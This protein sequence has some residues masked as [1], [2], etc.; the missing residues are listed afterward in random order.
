MTILLGDNTDAG[1]TVSLSSNGDVN[2]VEMTALASG[3]IGSVSFK[4][5]SY[6]SAS[7][8][9]I[10]E[11]NGASPTNLLG[12][13]EI[14][15]GVATGEV[16]TIPFPAVA[17]TAGTDYWIGGQVETTASVIHR[18]TTPASV[19]INWDNTSG[20]SASP[21]DPFV[22]AS[23]TSSTSRLIYFEDAAATTPELRKGKQFTVETTLTGTVTSA[24]LNGNA[25]TVDSHV[26]T[27]VT[28]TDSDGS[29]TTSGEYDLVLTDDVPANETITV[30]VNVIGISSHIF[31]KDGAGLASLSDVEIIVHNSAGTEIVSQLVTTTDINALI[32]KQDFSSV[33]EAVGD[34][35]KV[36]VY[37]PS[38]QVGITYEQALELI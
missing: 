38:A 31:A 11:S 33:S 13:A 24:T 35:V 4:L 6:G 14:P 34:T 17:I 32:P 16:V 23:G 22:K 7:R 25:I 19:D 20:W 9:C 15:S 18:G 28:L 26:G 29:I 1:T 10:Y 27:T 2:L 36:S 3:T 12:W 21:P 8:I 37:S 30:Q 5:N